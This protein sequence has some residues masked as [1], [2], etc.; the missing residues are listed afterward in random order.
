MAGR[1]GVEIHFISRVKGIWDPHRTLAKLMRKS[2]LNLTF[3][4]NKLVR[5]VS[6]LFRYSQVIIFFLYFFIIL[7]LSA[8]SPEASSDFRQIQIF[9]NFKKFPFINSVPVK[10]LEYNHEYN[11]LKSVEIKTK[12]SVNLFC[13]KK[14]RIWKRSLE[15]KKNLNLTWRPQ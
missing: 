11:H 12:H 13:L 4:S 2:S 15:S 5:D 9:K 8:L 6:S 3:F 14:R 10:S 1:T 7:K